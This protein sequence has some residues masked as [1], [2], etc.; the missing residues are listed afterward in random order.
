MGP[1]EEKIEP[2]FEIERHGREIKGLR[3]R[4]GRK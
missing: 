2:L 3:G 1:T 4:E